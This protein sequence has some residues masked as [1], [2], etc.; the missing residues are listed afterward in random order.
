MLARWM[1]QAAHQNEI[2]EAGVR[3]AW[4]IDGEYERDWE[5][6]DWER[7]SGRWKQMERPV[8][9]PSDATEEELA[10]AAKGN[11]FRLMYDGDGPALLGRIWVSDTD[12]ARTSEAC[13]QP[14]EDYGEGGYGCT[15]I[16]YRNA[17][18]EW[19]TL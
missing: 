11:P 14:L 8:R 2:A 1:A 13:W 4:V 16:Q 17:N 15:E 3:Y 12:H 6:D 10:K 18:N 19:E 7:D 5:H 9:G